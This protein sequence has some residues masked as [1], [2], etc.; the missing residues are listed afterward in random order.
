MI[1]VNKKNQ[2]SMDLSRSNT[3]K[4]LI[5]ARF[6]NLLKLIK[7]IYGRRRKVNPN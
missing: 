4:I 6:E 3:M 2:K 1:I 7:I 5:L